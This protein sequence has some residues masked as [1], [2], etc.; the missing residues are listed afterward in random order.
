MNCD[1]WFFP[2]CAWT[3]LSLL[4]G[5]S[6][7]YL[8]GSLVCLKAPALPVAPEGQDGLV[9]LEDLALSGLTQTDW[10]SDSG[11]SCS[12]TSGLMRRVA[13]Q[14]SEEGYINRTERITKYDF[15][16]IRSKVKKAKKNSRTR[17]PEW[18]NRNIFT[19]VIIM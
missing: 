11:L 4:D 13:K 6:V 1:V 5:H 17:T 10:G 7:H 12:V 8:R 16:I 15:K 2:L 18:C 14:T 3:N 19:V 9:P